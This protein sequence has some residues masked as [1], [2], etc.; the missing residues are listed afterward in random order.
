LLTALPLHAEVTA[1]PLVAEV[2]ALP[3]VA[4]VEALPLDTEETTFEGMAVTPLP[5]KEVTPLPDTVVVE[6]E[7]VVAVVAKRFRK[8]LSPTS[9]CSREGLMQ[10]LSVCGGAA[11]S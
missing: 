8:A 6:E 10:G 3:L 1:L 7:T 2:E 9:Y 5:R 4:E 11:S